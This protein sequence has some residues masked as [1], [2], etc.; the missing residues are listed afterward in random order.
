M[1]HLKEIENEHKE[2]KNK[3]RGLLGEQERYER[4]LKEM[5][6][7]LEQER[8]VSNDFGCKIIILSAEIE[9]NSGNTG[10]KSKEFLEM[11][12]SFY[13]LEKNCRDKDNEI[14][15]LSQKVISIEKQ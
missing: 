15:V 10:I 5:N 13:R 14:L 9:R 1:Y 8:R 11:K 4:T 6:D 3:I 7:Q 2:G 12:E